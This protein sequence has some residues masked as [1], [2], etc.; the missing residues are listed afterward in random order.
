MFVCFRGYTYKH[1]PVG[2]R[3]SLSRVPFW[4]HLPEFYV[5]MRIN[6]RVVI[7]ILNERNKNMALMNGACWITS[8]L[9]LINVILLYERLS[10]C[11]LFCIK[12]MPFKW[13]Q[14]AGHMPWNYLQFTFAKIRIIWCLGR[15]KESGHFAYLYSINAARK[16]TYLKWIIITKNNHEKLYSNFTDFSK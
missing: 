5:F 9:I 15:I 7:I 4:T 8:N 10:R 14:A 2:M 6:N 11:L 12:N 1:V 3:K 16:N 13:S